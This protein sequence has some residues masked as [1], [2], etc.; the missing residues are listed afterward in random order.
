MLNFQ[1]ADEWVTACGGRFTQFGRAHLTLFE[2]PLIT[3]KKAHSD[4]CLLFTHKKREEKKKWTGELVL[5]SENTAVVSIERTKWL[6][7]I[8]GKLPSWLRG[9]R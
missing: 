7:L 6:H 9:S 2:A 1:S 8:L 4:Y 5:V 3:G